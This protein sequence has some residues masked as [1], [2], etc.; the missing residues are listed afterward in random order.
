MERKRR[1]RV[2]PPMTN[3]TT[4]QMMAQNEDL[5]NALADVRLE[6]VRWKTTVKCLLTLVP[7]GE[8]VW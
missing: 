8:G 5:R 2:S 3:L 1:T 7:T 4:V 6:L